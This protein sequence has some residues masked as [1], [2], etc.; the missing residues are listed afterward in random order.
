[1][2]VLRLFLLGSP[3]F[4]YAGKPVT[5]SRRKA[6]ALLA[7]LAV[8]A[9]PRSRETLAALLWPESDARR[10]SASLRNSLWSLK[11]VLGEGWLD[12]TGENIGLNV[13]ANVWIDVAQFRRLLASCAEHDHSRDDVCSE[14]LPPLTDAVIL[15]RD[16]FLAGFTLADC[17]Q[18]DEWQFF[19]GQEL[20]QELTGALQ[21]LVQ[22]YI[23]QEELE[24]A[25]SYGRR[26]VSLDPLHEPAQRELI[27][28]YAM[29]GQRAAAL[30]QYE[31]CVSLLEEELSIPPEA[32]TTSLYEAIRTR[33][34]PESEAASIRW[35][36]QAQRPPSPVTVSPPPFMETADEAAESEGSVFV[37]RRRELERLHQALHSALHDEGQLIFVIGGA[38]RG[39]TMLVQEFMRQAQATADELLVVVGNGNAHVGIGDPY[40]PFREAL[41]MLTGDVEGKWSGGVITSSHARRLWEA[42]PITAPAL[43]DHAPDLIESFVPGKSLQARAET[44]APDDATWLFQLTSILSDAYRENLEQKHVFAQYTAVL[45]AIA[46]QRPLLLILEDLHWVDASSASLL[47]HLCREVG[48]SPILILGTYRP[49]EVAVSWRDIRHPLADIVGE[50]KRQLGDI[51]LDLGDAASEEGRQFVDAYLD[52]QPNRFGES[53]REALFKQTG[54]HALF[55]VQLL[56]N[57]RERGDI[58]QDGDGRWVAGDAIDWLTLPA[59]V[60]GA[61]EQRIGRL[62][63]ELQA[64]LTVASVEGESFTAEVVARVQ[65]VVERR[66]VQQLSHELDKQ[67]RLVTAQAF[68]RLNGQRLSHYR[69]RHH[70]FQHY[71]YQHLSESERA[72]LHEE[73]GTALEALYGDRADMVAIQLAWHF[74]EAGL[75]GKAIDYLQMAGKHAARSYAG[76]EAVA[77]YEEALRLL[78]TLPD[79]TERTEREL[80]L[81]FTIGNLM[82]GSRGYASAEMGRAY[83]RAL[84]L[85]YHVQKI[86]SEFLPLIFG[87]YTF[88]YVS[89]NLPKAREFSVEFMN[90]ARR[91]KDPAM[92]MVSHRLMMGPLW[93][94]GEYGAAQKH[95]AEILATYDVQQ[96]SN[97]VHSYGQDTGVVALGYQ[98]WSLWIVGFPE[99]A[100]ARV[101][102][103][104]TLANEVAHPLSRC[105]A[106][107]LAAIIHHYRGEIQHFQSHVDDCLSLAT[108]HRIPFFVAT[109]SLEQGKMIIE[110]GDV[111]GG[112]AKMQQGLTDLATAG[113]KLLRPYFFSVLIEAFAQAGQV[114]GGL[115]VVNDTLALVEE[116]G[117]R[118]LEPELYRLKGE[119]M[120]AAAFGVKEVAV[121]SDPIES[122][123]DALFQKAIAVARRQNARSLELRAVMSLN[124]LWQKQGKQKQAHLM[125]A[126]IFD[127]FTEGFDTGDLIEARRLLDE[128]SMAD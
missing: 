89:A 23:G 6:I 78:N 38:G 65:Q 67:H 121:K 127:W 126:E 33:R 76:R 61:I 71:L 9:E 4:E 95:I 72:Y 69:F 17:P 52:T 66:L 90:V 19:Q 68:E 98:A 37:G 124:R 29:A 24:A 122:T 111:V 46:A 115:R 45:K 91:Q 8:L 64:I 114:E 94:M 32:A 87:L 34:F 31:E 112:L 113:L 80:H 103:A 5:T 53:F 125:L 104:V 42:M 83:N 74:Q 41:T 97:L 13:E 106:H 2:S 22:W 86:P 27:R 77:Y 54:G 11:Q 117:E 108:E 16:D 49:E 15:Y 62:E 1:M 30:R 39:K 105:Y 92:I 63:A 73:V 28:L 25:L 109:A 10:A 7:Y 50:L 118:H 85:S 119:L 128:L 60:E 21:R 84:E 36:S 35:S 75:V 102:E 82:I 70:L 40:L 55:T 99:Q 12:V 18:F 120:L 88:N 48:D 79:T 116:T 57:M 3:Q 43:V 100:L 47:F 107:W 59:K 44:M 20:R 123:P 26:W 58:R 81:Q 110:K 101:Q 14:C 56:R 51:W 93:S 96:H